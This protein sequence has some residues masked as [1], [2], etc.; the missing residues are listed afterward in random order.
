M[1]AVILFALLSIPVIILSWRTFFNVKSHGFYR[2]FSWECIIWLFISNYPFWFE[3]PLGFE[4]KQKVRSISDIEK[5][6]PL[7][8]SFPIHHTKTPLKITTNS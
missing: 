8:A 7:R 3:N 4:T 1:E 2:F 5:A 6:C